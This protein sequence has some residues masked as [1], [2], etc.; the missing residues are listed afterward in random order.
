MKPTADFSSF[1]A[2]D[3][4][5]GR[6]VKVE[7][8]ETRKPLYRVTV[9]LGSE[10][11]EKVSVAGYA[12]YPKEELVGRL[13]VTVVNFAPKKMGPEMSEL[14]I[15]GAVGENDEGIFITPESDVRPG[16]IVI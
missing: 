1:D 4:R 10:I 5:I 9:D 13:V 15:L 16:S 2:L 8:A 11:G 14:F 12:N 6:V 7:D 3:L